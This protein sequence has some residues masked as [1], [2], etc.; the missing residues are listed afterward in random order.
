MVMLL[1]RCSYERSASVSRTTWFTSTIAR[2]VWRLRAKVSRLRTIFAA[3]SDSLRIVSRPRRVWSSVCRCDEALCPRQD[4]RERIVQL[5]RDTGDRLAERRE[6]LGLQQLVIQ[7]ARLVLEPLSL[8]DIA[9]Q[10]FDAQPFRPAFGVRRDFDPDRRPIG[11][12]QP[13]QVVGDRTITI[14]TLEETLARQRVDEAIQ[15]E[16]TDLVLRDLARV[17]E[18]QLEVRI[19][20]ERERRGLRHRP[21]VHAFVHR[22]EQT[23]KGFRRRRRSRGCS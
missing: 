17:A 11:A 19:R 16:W 12:A 2:V 6:L 7:V 22:L 4:C 15:L 14:E 1:T 3:R 5:V 18:H 21:D 23:G 13:K 10:R 8:A 9:H 20:R